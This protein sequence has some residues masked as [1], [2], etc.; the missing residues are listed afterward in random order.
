MYYDGANF[1][2]ILGITSPGLMGFDSVHFNLHKTF[3]SPTAE[4]GRAGTH[5]RQG[6][7][8]L[9]RDRRARRRPPAK[10]GLQRLTTSVPLA[11]TRAQHR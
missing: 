2:A 3:S 11:P 10:S 7:R 6:Y 8:T 1:N 4:A 5:W 9:C